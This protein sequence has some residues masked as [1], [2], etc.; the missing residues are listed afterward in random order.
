MDALD[1][2]VAGKGALSESDGPRIHMSDTQRV[3]ESMREILAVL[4]SNRPL[5][6]TLDRIIVEAGRL[7][8]TGSGAI[9]RLEEGRS[10]VTIQAA[11][12]LPVEYVAK[13]SIPV[14]MG[15]V[16]LSVASH[17]PV[18]VPDIETW[19]RGGA[20]GLDTPRQEMVRTLTGW[21]AS[22]LAVPLV[23]QGHVYGGLVLYYRAPREFTESDLALAGVLGDYVA[24]AIENARLRERGELAAVE[25][26]RT[27]LARD[28]HDSVT[29]TLFSAGLIA[30]VLPG[31]WERSPGEGQRRLGE[32]QHLVKGALADMRMLL[33][34][35]RPAA[36][37][38]AGLGDLLRQL[39]AATG[40]R[41]HIPVELEVH[42]QRVL[43][44]D[45]Q[46]ALYR[47]AQEAMNNVARHAQATHAQVI[48]RL[49]PES[50]DLMVSDDGRGFDA[51]GPIRPEHLGLRI[52]RERAEATGAHVAVYSRP[53][54]GTQVR[55]SWPGTVPGEDRA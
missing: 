48:L 26:E 14:G 3:S 46:I 40:G 8:A 22:L 9:F 4:N 23:M 13:M 45:V 2:S 25:A 38:E 35:L 18:V 42:G 17:K 5:A 21:Y 36:L 37:T 19:L 29:Q 50:A 15:A 20:M 30:D 51:S 27:R 55:A 34:E 7:L 32:L 24:L 43:P 44:P 47:I 11:R 12:G 53:G 31:L 10:V 33:V 1:A 28:L 39:C 41:A 6:E 54:H 16:G 52:M 49:S